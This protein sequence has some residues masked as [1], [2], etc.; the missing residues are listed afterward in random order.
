MTV[1]QQLTH[2]SH[3]TPALFISAPGSG[4]GKTTVTAALA[5]W[6]RRQGRRV[7]VFKTGPDFL[8]PSI[9]AQA[10]GQPVYQ[11]DLW[12]MGEQ[13]CRALVHQATGEADVILVEGVMGLFDG[14]PS[15]ADLADL[16][17]LPVAAVVNVAGVAQ[18]LGAIAYG[19]AHYRPGLCFAGVLA[20]GVASA[21]HAE[22]LQQGLPADLAWLGGMPRECGFSLPERHL[23]LVPAAEVADLE[24]RLDAA[25]N[26]VGKLPLAQLPEDIHFA[27]AA[28]S[29]LPPLLQGQHIAVARDAAF[30]FLYQSN[31]DVLQQLGA[32]LHFFSPLQDHALPEAD[33]VY[34]PGGYPELHLQALQDNV[35]MRQALQ[36]HCVAGKRLYAECGGM[37]YLLE[38]LTDQHGDSAAMLGILPGQAVL[39]SRLQGLG[40][41]TMRLPAGALRCHTFHYSNITTDL[42]AFSVGERLFASSAGE[43]VFCRD[44][45]TASYLHACFASSP[46]ATAS[47]FLPQQGRA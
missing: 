26:V 22:M 6:H 36:A 18:T 31:L 28:L 27:P 23:G 15:S 12:M 9:L 32:Q 1:S 17:Q 24:Q 25:A 45:I 30:C 33:S 37:L 41:Q 19:L 38:R 35:A 43:R 40:Y 5:R 8:D 13:A 14:Q 10:S 16:L 34:L 29:T 7:R 47:L 3:A 4:H 21:R 42:P 44:G 2:A 46:Q 39:Q 11:L 20:N